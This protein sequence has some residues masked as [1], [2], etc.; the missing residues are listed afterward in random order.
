MK[1]NKVVLPLALMSSL[2]SASTA[3]TKIGVYNPEAV[4]AQSKEWQAL[5]GALEKDY[6]ARTT[7][8]KAEGD[9]LRAAVQKFQEKASMLSET[10]RESEQDSLMRKDRDF[11]AKQQRT[12]DDYKAD[13]QKI[14]VRFLKKLEDSV[15]QFAQKNG[16]SILTPKG[17]GV[18][19]SSDVD[20]TTAII[21][22]MNGSYQGDGKKPVAKS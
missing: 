17:P 15:A 13:H 3:P 2:L 8:I 10:A 18:Y 11:Q 19:A 16:F 6:E 7:A 5:N 9:A 4:A 12:M 14:M 22:F 21:T 1:I 20:Q